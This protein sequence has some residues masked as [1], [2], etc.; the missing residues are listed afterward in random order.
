MWHCEVRNFSKCVCGISMKFY[1]MVQQ[2][3]GYI[4]STAFF[5]KQNSFVVI[6]LMTIITCFKTTKNISKIGKKYFLPNLYSF[7]KNGLTRCRHFIFLCLCPISA[8]DYRPLG[9][10]FAP[11]NVIVHT[12]LRWF[13]WQR[14]TVAMKWSVRYFHCVAI[15]LCNTKAQAKY[16][17]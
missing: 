10:N 17:K 16:R 8:R 2:W 9:W 14:Q 11:R 3:T 5:E 15:Q 6:H 13:P 7:Q 12:C 4:V 1:M